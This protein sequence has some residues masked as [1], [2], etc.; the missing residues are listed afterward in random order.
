MH[1][2][3]CWFEGDFAGARVH[4]ERA[5]A[6]F[7]PQR[8]GDLAFRFGQDVGVSAMTYLAPALW[9]VGEITRAQ[10]LEDAMIVRA[11]EIGHVATL[12]YAAGN[13]ALFEMIRH[14][15]RA[16]APFAAETSELGRTHGLRTIDL[17]GG[18]ASEWAR[19]RLGEREGGAARMR[20]AI[21]R[22]QLHSTLHASLFVALLAEL[23]A[24]NGKIDSAVGAI[25]RALAEIEQTGQ[26]T[27]E[28]EVHRI[29]GEILLKR[30][31]AN[32]APAEEALETAIGV[33]R[34]Q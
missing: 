26:R 12:A 14:D 25:D 31:P 4:L 2:T 8:H 29:R 20:E 32:P 18:V 5:L 10:E 33:A 23:E 22:R 1:G 24:E 13:R 17:L 15:A 21:E 16:A 3:T 34:R 19:A 28:A 27:F 11:R 7:D 6:T 9:S 30:D